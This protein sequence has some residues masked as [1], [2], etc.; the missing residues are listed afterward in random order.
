M[1][2]SRIIRHGNAFLLEVNGEKL[3]LYAYLTYQP[4]KGCYEDFKKI[5]VRLFFCTMYACDRGINQNSGIRPFRSGFWKGYGKYDFSEVDADLRTVTGNSK[6]GEIYIIPRLMVEAPSWW[7]EEN[8]NE[9]CRDAHGTPLH[10]SF[11]SKKWIEDVEQMLCDLQKWVQESGWDRY[12][13]GWHIAAGNTEEFIRPNHRPKQMIDYSEPARKDFCLFA[14][15]KYGSIEKANAVWRKS[16]ASF[17]DISLP[18]AMQRIYGN[19]GSLHDEKSEKFVIDYYAFMNAGMAKAA[20]ALCAAAKRVTE[21]QQIIGAFYGYLAC[22]SETGQHAASLLFTSENVDFI[23]S[24]FAYTDNRGQG[25]DWQFQGSIESAALHGK[26]WFMEADVR[27][28]LSRPISESFKKA[29]PYVNRAYDG[30]VWY[31]PDTVEGSLGQMKK[32]FAKV[33]THNTA[34][35][36]FDMWGGWYKDE[37]YMDFHQKAYRLYAETMLSGGVTNASE[38]ALFMDDATFYRF[39]PGAISA[40]QNQAVWKHLGKIGAPYKMFMMDDLPDIDP[41]NFR[42]AIFCT[43]CD[44]TAERLS[45]LEKWKKDGRAL[46]FLGC[47]EQ[48][49]ASGFVLDEAPW[50]EKLPE[51]Q[52]MGAVETP[53]RR[54]ALTEHDIVLKKDEMG[55]L[56]VLRRE[57]N[58]SVCASISMVPEENTLRDLLNGAAGMLYN[59]AGDVVYASEDYIAV[60]AASD[61]CKRIHVPKKCRMVEVFTGETLPGNECFVDVN[62]KKGDTLLLKTE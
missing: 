55:A 9:V 40:T 10:Q 48:E 4:E 13:I 49:R 34:I 42:M 54:I 12:V 32:A 18:T 59:T 51:N 1:L 22:S 57:E 37:R 53:L 16:F 15:E 30:P 44:W 61:G 7:D 41:E 5:G 46:V 2:E 36:W 17:E 28:H 62:M 35:W 23:A 50:N 43:P 14:K 33:L 47:G 8:P 11:H 56:C 26:P 39:T 31:G 24:P 19:H 29:D 3:P 58:F 21:H 20:D 27:T 45:A 60:H 25:V 52:E 38:T 6:P